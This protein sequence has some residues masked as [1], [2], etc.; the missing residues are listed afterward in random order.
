MGSTVGDIILHCPQYGIYQNSHSLGS[1]LKVMQDLYHQPYWVLQELYQG[2]R[3]LL[4]LWDT[5][6]PKP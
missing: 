2:F 5:L 4:G 1:L 6:N 3:K